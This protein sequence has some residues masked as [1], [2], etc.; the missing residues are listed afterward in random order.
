M[1]RS[2]FYALDVSRLTAHQ[3]VAVGIERFGGNVKLAERIRFRDLTNADSVGAQ[4]GRWA[5]A[6]GPRVP[7]DVAI[8]VL[9]ALGAIDW[10]KV[11]GPQESAEGAEDRIAEKSALARGR[12]QKPSSRQ[13][14]QAEGG[15]RP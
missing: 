1:C 7:G 11:S 12:I 15:S 6:D 2:S 10:A 4:I 13:P 5:S 3:I 14:R 8:R 9:D